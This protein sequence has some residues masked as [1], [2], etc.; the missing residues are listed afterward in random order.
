MKQCVHTTICPAPPARRVQLGLGG[1]GGGVKDRVWNTVAAT[2][3]LSLCVAF[4]S[5]P[6]A[7][8]PPQV[9]Q[10]LF[11]EHGEA[12][13]DRVRAASESALLRFRWDRDVFTCFAEIWSQTAFDTA[14][15]PDSW[16]LICLVFDNQRFL[17]F[18]Y[19]TDI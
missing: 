12:G 15:L 13:F 2:L 10:T 3:P 19:F 7:G 11:G 9:L 14:L 17:L 4:L 16:A 6:L 8:P 5:S 18:V 1:F